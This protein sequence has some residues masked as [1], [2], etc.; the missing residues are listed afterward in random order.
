MERD[1]IR[2]NA[3]KGLT[4]A[5]EAHESGDFLSVGDG[6]DDYDEKLKRDEHSPDDVLFITLMFWEAW[7]DSAE[8]TWK[9]YPPFSKDDWPKMA[10]TLLEDLKADNKVTDETILSH[11]VQ[12]PRAP[13]KSFLEKIKSLMKG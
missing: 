1:E 8:H 12:K 5:I 10:R 11:F 2:A 6:Y 13:K 3:I 4:K 9:F 7:A